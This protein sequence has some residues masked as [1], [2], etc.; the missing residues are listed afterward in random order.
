MRIDDYKNAI[1]LSIEELSKKEPIDIARAGGADFYQGYMEFR[2][3]FRKARI[4]FPQ[5]AITWAPPYEAEDFTLTDQ[6]LVLHYF[7][8]AKNDGLT[9]DLVAYRQIPGGEFYTDA[10]ARRALIP[11][12]L[13]F[14][15]KPGLL[16]KASQALGGKIQ[17]GMGD[18]AALFRVFPH[19]DILVMLY[20]A[21]EEFEANGQVLF[22]AVVG[23]YFSNEDISWLGSSLVYRLMGE[24]KRL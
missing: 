19:I 24:A 11:L 6:V 9:G 8:G 7:Q 1:N 12:A 21:D 18:E 10:F 2:Y 14:G 5:W 20:H 23:K 16:T 4:S 13:V 17:E 15:S 22:D 3:L